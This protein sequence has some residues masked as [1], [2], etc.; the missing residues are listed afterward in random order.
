MTLS[1]ILGRDVS[2]EWHEAVA[3]V[4]GVVERLLEKSSQAIAVPELDQIEIS[5]AGHVSVSGGT[6]AG[7]PVRRLGQLLQAMLGYTESPVQLRLVVVQA[8]APARPRSARF[9]NT[10]R[11]WGTSNDRA[12]TP[13]S[14]L[15]MHERRLRRSAPTRI[16]LPRW[17]QSLR[18]RRQIGLRN[19]G[20]TPS[21][22][23]TRVAGS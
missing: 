11:P 5:A 12:A 2:L 13:C 8:T 23:R 21:R 19:P 22:N 16:T 4:R 6:N 15:S 7:E 3:L 17:T 18:C 10:T 1:D 20:K 9:A 14:R